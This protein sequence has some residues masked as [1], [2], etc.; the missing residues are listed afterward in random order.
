MIGRHPSENVRVLGAFVAPFVFMFGLYVIAHGHYGPGGGFAGGVILA[1]AV[2]LVRLVVD[3]ELGDRLFPPSA[4]LVTMSLGMA[5]FL[6]IGFIPLLSGG[7]FL[8]YSAVPIEAVGDARLRYLGILVA[9]LAIG[10]VV[11]AGIVFIFDLLS[12]TERS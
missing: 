12:R 5:A 9:E 7:A 1:V 11:F 8:D 2:V 10:V 3:V 6:A 4:A